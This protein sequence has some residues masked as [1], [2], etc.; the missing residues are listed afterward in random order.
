MNKFRKLR[1]NEKAA[2]KKVNK[3]RSLVLKIA[4]V[5]LNFIFA[6]FAWF[7]HT[8]N[9]ETT[10]DVK[11]SAWK[12]DFKEGSSSIVGEEIQIQVTDFYPG[13]PDD[14]NVKK[15]TIENL[16]EKAASISYEVSEL[17]ILGQE[18]TVKETPA[19]GD[20][21]YTVYKSETTD[22]ATGTKTIK[23]LNDTSKFPFEITITHTTADLGIA[24]AAHPEQNKGEFQL[25]FTW[26]YELDGTATQ[27]Q[28]EQKD[29]LD[30]KWGYD[31][32]TFYNAL[33]AGA[34]NKAVEVTVQALVKQII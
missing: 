34:T 27:E 9:L 30:T 15:I 12:V 20:S 6:T 26:P 23:L 13:V 7:A 5:T 10:V 4:L 2:K 25:A 17:F 18:Y 29:T 24:N 28:K 14:T 1:K 22:V 16:G 8:M 32:A 21:P 3:I 11:V 19:A 31:T 33:A